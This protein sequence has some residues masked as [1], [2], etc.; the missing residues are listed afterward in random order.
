MHLRATGAGVTAYVIDTGIARAHAQSGGRA[1]NVYDAFG[2]NGQDCNGHGTHVCGMIGASTYGVAKQVRLRGLRVLG[3]GGSGSTSG[4]LAAVDW[5]RRDAARPAVAD[6][7]LGGGYCSTLNS[8]VQ[9]LNGSGVFVSLA[10]GNENRDACTTSPASAS[11]TLDVAAADR[12]GQRAAFSDSG[13]C[14]D[15]CAAGVGIRR[16]GSAAGRA[17]S[18]ARRWPPRTPPAWPRSPGRRAAT[19]RARHCS[20][21]S[22]APHDRRGRRQPS[23]TPDRLLYTSSL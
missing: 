2:G 18:A 19:R 22:P 17:A 14:I 10:A 8:A 4:I 6:M 21:G 11:G 5:L 20:A 13:S 16:P 7:S 12:A 23:R 9:N 3:C 1:A 15:L